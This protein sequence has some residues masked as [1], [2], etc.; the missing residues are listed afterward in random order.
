MN[1]DGT[2][3]FKNEI[4]LLKKQA[5]RD[6]LLELKETEERRQTAIFKSKVNRFKELPRE[7]APLEE[8]SLNRVRF[9][10]PELETSAFRS[11]IPRFH[12][13]P[14]TTHLGPGEYLSVSYAR[15]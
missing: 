10:K 14:D 4:Y 8:T 2:F 9:I 7:E 11:A 12:D 5:L 13:S 6:T 15:P 1:Q 3:S